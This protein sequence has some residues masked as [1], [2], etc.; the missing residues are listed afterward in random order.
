MKKSVLGILFLLWSSVLMAQ[1]A[2]RDTLQNKK[3]KEIV[4]LESHK[5]A[6]F[7]WSVV[8]VANPAFALINEGGAYQF[9]YTSQWAFMVGK[10]NQAKIFAEYSYIPERFIPHIFRMGGALDI[11]AATDSGLIF[12][13]SF[14][15]TP[16]VALFADFKD[17]GISAEYALWLELMRYSRFFVRYRFNFWISNAS[18]GYQD[19]AIGLSMPF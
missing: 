9:G 16:G 12:D 13:Y 19:F 8:R 10:K 14:G 15:F 18:I 4:R 5:I 6:G 1:F 17:Y 7:G 11:I 3:P 2:Y